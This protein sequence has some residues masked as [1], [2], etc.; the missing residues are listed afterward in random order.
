MKFTFYQGNTPRGHVNPADW[1]WKLTAVNGNNVANGGEGYERLG[2]MCKSLQSVFGDSP[3]R[4][5]ELNKAYRVCEKEH[6][7]FKKPF[8]FVYATRITLG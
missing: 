7:P 8:E 1:R 5:A 3:K 2:G 4:V 6:G